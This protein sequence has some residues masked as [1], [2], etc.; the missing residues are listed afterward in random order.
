MLPPPCAIRFCP[1]T[2]R[3]DLRPNLCTRHGHLV[4]C[5]TCDDWKIR[6]RDLCKTCRGLWFVSPEMAE[7]A[8]RHG[9][10]WRARERHPRENDGRW[11]AWEHA[12][13]DEDDLPP[14]VREF[15]G[16]PGSD[17]DVEEADS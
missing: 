6:D 5:P 7:Y 10:R 13:V 12:D 8:V 9:M 17:L 15:P 2:A 1:N 4:V 3:P 11:P 14:P 16:V